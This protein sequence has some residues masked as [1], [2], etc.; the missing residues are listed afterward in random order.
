MK[1]IIYNHLHKG[2]RRNGSRKSDRTDELHS[3]IVS[4]ISDR[5]EN[6]HENFSVRY[7]SKIPCVY[8]NTFS[9]DIAICDKD[10]GKLHTVV[11]AKA[12][13]SS[14][15]KNRANNANTSIGEIC[16]I[17]GANPD[18]NVFFVT[19]IANSIPNYK[20]DICNRMNKKDSSYIDLD[21]V[22]DDINIFSDD[23]KS[24]V[25][26]GTV[27]YD[28]SGIDYHT[29]ESFHDTLLVDNVENILLRLG[30]FQ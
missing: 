18:V 30:N 12:F 1:E 21:K 26:F 22:F 19:Y 7:E 17:L 5:V 20:G 24:K 11:L 25:Y 2:T 15:Q 29:K 27:S 23:V 9:V 10:T 13:V 14:V 4:C 6:F 8:G 16:R 3:S 28:L